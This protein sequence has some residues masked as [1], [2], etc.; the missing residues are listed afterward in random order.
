MKSRGVPGVKR[1]SLGVPPVYLSRSFQLMISL[2]RRPKGRCDQ[3]LQEDRGVGDPHGEPPAQLPLGE[4]DFSIGPKHHEHF[5]KN[6]FWSTGNHE[7]LNFMDIRID[8]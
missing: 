7:K 1:F 2:I 6:V 3:R 8:F 4:Y 5:E